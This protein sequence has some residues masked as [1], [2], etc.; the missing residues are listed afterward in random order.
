LKSFSVPGTGIARNYDHHG[1]SSRLNGNASGRF[2]YHIPAHKRQFADLVGFTNFDLIEP[3]HGSPD[4]RAH[5]AAL[6]IELDRSFVPTI[7]GDLESDAGLVS[8]RELFS[9]TGD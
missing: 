5:L 4:T 3:V 2:G 7:D 9:R 6:V 1:V 8:P